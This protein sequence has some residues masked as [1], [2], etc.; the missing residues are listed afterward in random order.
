MVQVLTQA[1][2]EKN[3]SLWGTKLHF[4]TLLLSTASTLTNYK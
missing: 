4:R 1:S 3:V 2:G